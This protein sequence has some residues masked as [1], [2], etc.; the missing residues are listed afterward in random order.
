M[1]GTF[2][3]AQSAADTG[4]FVDG[5]NNLAFSA[6][7]VD[8]A[9]DFAQS[10]ADAAVGNHIDQKILADTGPAAVI[11]DMAKIFLFKILEGGENG[12]GGRLAQSAQGGIPDGFR[13]FPQEGDVLGLSVS[14][15]DLFQGL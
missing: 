12:V 2:A 11:G 14:F 15:G 13:Q 6:D 3:V 1:N 10:T 8:G 7:A 5:M 9:V 4:A